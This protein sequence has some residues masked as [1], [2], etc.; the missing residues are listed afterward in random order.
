M[1]LVSARF[2][3]QIFLGASPYE[4]M[5]EGDRHVS[6]KSKIHLEVNDKQTTV[7]ISVIDDMLVSYVTIVP[8]SN[9]ACLVYA[10]DGNQD[11]VKDLPK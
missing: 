10:Y 4:H 9:I 11:G 2:V 6:P 8:F 5:N 1:K 7:R 3:K